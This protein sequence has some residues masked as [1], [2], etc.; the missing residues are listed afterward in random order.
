MSSSVAKL[1]FVSGL[2][3]LVPLVFSTRG[4]AQE[5]SRTIEG[6]WLVQLTFRD[7]ADGTVLRSA[8]GL[9][10]FLPGGTMLGTPSSPTAAVRTGH[11]VWRHVGESRFFSRMGLWAYNPQT[12]ALLGLRVVLRNIEVGPGPD[13]FRASDTE[14]VYDPTTLTR[15]GAQSCIT[16]I[17]RRVP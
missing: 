10:T 8:F 15:V 13:E 4:E 5:P 7:C 6:T 1:L 9:N 11:G 3:V 2:A 16:G 12:G 14:Q 17:G